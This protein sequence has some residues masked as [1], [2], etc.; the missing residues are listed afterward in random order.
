MVSKA[1][2]AT[3]AG[4]VVAGATVAFYVL[5][6]GTPEQ[7]VAGAGLFGAVAFVALAAYEDWQDARRNTHGH[8]HRA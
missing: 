3:I 6:S 2:L 4:G 5:G 8:Q 1:A 7:A